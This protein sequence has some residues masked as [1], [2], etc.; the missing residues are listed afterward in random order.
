MMKKI[1]KVDLFD[2]ALLA[3]STLTLIYANK[4][5]ISWLLLLLVLAIAL[6][7]ALTNGLYVNKVILAWMINL[8]WASI[9]LM[10]APDFG[11]GLSYVI[12]LGI[13]AISLTYNSGKAS[14]Q[15]IH[16]LFSLI[17]YIY[18]LAVVLEIIFPADIGRIRRMYAASNQWI[19]R[20]DRLISVYN[21]KFGFFVDPAVSAF[22]CSFCVGVGYLFLRRHQ[23]LKSIVWLIP[24]VVGLVLTNK[25]GPILFTVVTVIIMYIIES[26]K[27]TAT[28]IKT[29]AVLLLVSLGGYYLMT[30]NRVVQEWLIKINSNVASNQ[31]RLGAYASQ[32]ENFI[33]HPFWGSGTKSSSSILNGMDGH[34]IY[35]A[36]LSE[37]GLFGFIILLYCL[38]AGLKLT[39]KTY[40]QL[41]DSFDKNEVMLALYMQ[42]FICL[43]GFTGNPFSNLYSLAV[44]FTSLGIVIRTHRRFCLIP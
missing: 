22:Y 33:K 19:D 18:M 12:K 14:N 13:L 21:T 3:L 9:G 20:T 1:Y 35:L 6:Y 37:N 24:A 30:E 36:A 25:R 42:M 27:N 39:L 15:K 44:Y 31:N 2:T 38:L 5:V 28:K 10:Y 7:N 29:I 23:Y 8:C 34:N 4:S 11:K 32:W 16:R 40:A 41:S 43:Y 26:K 17:A